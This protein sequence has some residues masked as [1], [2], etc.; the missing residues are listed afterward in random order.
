M[1]DI[2]TMIA[3]ELI[4]QLLARGYALGVNDGEET[5][6]RNSSDAD[7][8][9]DS[10]RSTYDDYILVAEPTKQGEGIS[11]RQIGWVQLIWGNGIDLISDYSMALIDTVGPIETW[12]NTL[13]DWDQLRQQA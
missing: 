3:K 5:V 4:T 7:E 8:V 1:Q 2:E 6:L 13:V 12:V 10:L 9:F 11:W